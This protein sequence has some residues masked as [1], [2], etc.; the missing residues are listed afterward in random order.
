[1]KLSFCGGLLPL[2]GVCGS[3]VCSTV[4]YDRCCLVSVDTEPSMCAAARLCNAFRCCVTSESPVDQTSVSDAAWTTSD[5]LLTTD[6]HDVATAAADKACS[7]RFR[8][9]PG[10]CGPRYPY[11]DFDVDGPSAPVPV[12]CCERCDGGLFSPEVSLRMCSCL[13]ATDAD[14]VTT[15]R[16]LCDSRRQRCAWTGDVIYLD[17][18]EKAEMSLMSRDFRGVDLLVCIKYTRLV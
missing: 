8:H 13:L 10:S 17:D 4:N 11:I 1:M 2:S 3:E 15:G 9:F 5:T 6:E 7:M 14:H 16:T 12:C 18:A